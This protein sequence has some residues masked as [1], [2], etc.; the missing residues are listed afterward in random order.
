MKNKCVKCIYFE[1]ERGEYGGHSFCRKNKSEFWTDEPC[2]ETAD[3]TDKKL[4]LK[5]H[6]KEQERELEL[7]IDHLIDVNEKLKKLK[8]EYEF[9]P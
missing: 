9:Q 1:D 5:L 3:K 7:S 6:I 8:K 4:M 2:I